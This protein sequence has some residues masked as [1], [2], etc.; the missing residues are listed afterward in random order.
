MLK[1]KKIWFYI[2]GFWVLLLALATIR[3]LSLPDE[4]RYADV[5]RWMLIS[6]DWLVPRLNGIPFFHKPPLLYWMQAAVF[7][8]AGVHVWTAR[9]VIALHALLLLVGVYFGLKPLYKDEPFARKVLMVIGSSVGF[10]I[11]GQYINHDFM[12]AAWIS[13][14][15]ILF[16]LSLRLDDTTHRGLARLGFVACGLG[17]LSKGLI[18][19]AL[20]G[21]V[22]F[23]WLLLTGRQRKMLDFPWLSGFLIFA[24]ITMPWMLLAQHQNPGFFDYF[25]IAQH[26]SRFTGSQFN[27]QQAWWFYVPIIALYLF[28]W[29]IIP[30][31]DF[32][33]K[34]KINLKHSQWGIEKPNPLRIL[35]WVWL[36][37]ILVF[38]SVPKSKL[39]G[40]ILPA[41]PPVAMLVVQSWNNIQKRKKY[42]QFWFWIF[43]GLSVATSLGLNFLARHNSL[44]NASADVADALKCHVQK[45]DEIY[46][47]GEYPY[48]FSFAMNGQKPITVVQDWDD[49]KKNALDDWR[50]IFFEGV[51]FDEK[52]GQALLNILDF[53]KIQPLAQNW[54][55]APANYPADNL[56]NKWH[57]FYKGQKWWLWR[58]AAPE[59][60]DPI[61][62]AAELLQKT[63]R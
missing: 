2:L 56:K 34:I 3:P 33:Q 12:V 54:V 47:L 31:V 19:L 1:S 20:P 49:A 25:I 61:K 17:F 44:Q 60:A 38:F 7:E 10:L 46:V 37:V 15:V 51:H 45:Q 5:G 40:Y 28:P 35:P 11:G 27:S 52:S 22:I 58:G 9:W 13:I 18:G 41:I 62:P 6:G 21:A 24:A 30:V 57:V 50:R 14:S 55:V 63:C 48:D 39:I 53:E 26:F 59:G 29:V 36:L 43:C 4:G 16:A 42:P 32:F 23:V 8:W